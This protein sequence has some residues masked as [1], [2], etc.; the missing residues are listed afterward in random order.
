MTFNKIFLYKMKWCALAAVLFFLIC[1]LVGAQ[2]V[3]NK[4]ES[5]ADAEA[6]EPSFS[7]FP[8]SLLYRAAL[9][10]TVYFSPDRD[11]SIPVDAFNIEAFSSITLTFYED[12]KKDETENTGEADDTGTTIEW[13]VSKN[14][15]GLLTRFPYSFNGTNYFIEVEYSKNEI[16]AFKVTGGGNSIY[17][18]LL[19]FTDESFLL[20]TG[21]PA[22]QVARLE[23]EGAYYF[24]SFTYSTM[25][26]IETFFSESGEAL[27]L[28]VNNFIDNNGRFSISSYKTISGGL[29][30]EITTTIFYNS[31]GNISL[32]VAGDAQFQADYNDKGVRYW[33]RRYPNNEENAETSGGEVDAETEKT[34]IFEKIEVRYNENKLPV[35]AIINDGKGVTY[36]EYE[37][38]VDQAGNWIERRELHRLDKFNAGI[39]VPASE[40]T[41]RR[42]IVY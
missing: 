9:G 10:E 37:Y 3:K 23:A 32:S 6:G 15:D 1:A 8:L 25:E 33:S 21:N 31:M 41:I 34:E 26:I 4:T 35:G 36:I 42:V 24:V 14:K 38:D 7:L 20:L 5:E 27:F 16:K 29:P 13:T 12:Q 40:K 2:E 22:P 19:E 18:E 39:L 30:P 11:F 17:I 28:Y